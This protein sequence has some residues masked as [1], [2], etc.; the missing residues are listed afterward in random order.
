MKITVLMENS[1]GDDPRLIPEHGLSLLIETKRHRLL[2]DTGPSPHTWENAARLGVDLS[3]VDTV[4]LSHGHYDH[5]GGV[6]SLAETHPGLTV[7]LQRSALGAFYSGERYIGMDPRIAMLPGLR[8][9][10]GD[11]VIDEELSLFA[12][13]TGRR[14]WPASNLALSE[15]V[16]GVRRQDRFLHEQ[17]LVVHEEE[18]LVLVT[19]CAHNGILNLLDRFRDHYHR[20]PDAV[21]S[22]F[23]MMKKTAYTEEETAAIEETGHILSSLQTEFWTGHCTGTAAGLLQEVMG[24]KLHLLHTGLV[25]DL[26]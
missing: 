13:I 18:R 10:D 14:L 9:L 7:Y 22:G 25:I 17:F 11:F 12:P 20:D 24:P 4:I 21:I 15:I 16:A 8:L 6:M 23:H 26:S 2:M 1:P 19:G 5:T 3:S